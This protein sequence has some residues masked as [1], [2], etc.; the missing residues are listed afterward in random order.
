MKSDSTD[1]A[2]QLTSIAEYSKTAAALAELR[3]KYKDVIFDVATR[4][5]MA[6]AIKGRAELRGYRLAL[7]RLRVEI[8]APALKRTQEID[9][10]ARR[11]TAELLALEDPIDDQIKADE[12]RKQAEIEAKAKAEADRIAAE[13]A[14]RK[15]AEEKIL[16]AQRAEIERQQAELAERKRQQ[17]A[18]EYEARRKIEAE[19]RAAR[20]EIEEE[21][22]EAQ[23]VLD[24][25][26]E[27]MR[28]EQAE[29]NKRLREVEEKLAAERRAVE[30]QARQARAEAEA[31][32]REVRRK[33][34]E[35]NDGY[36]ILAN[37]VRR[38][39]RIDEFKA[40]AQA[41][42]PYLKKVNKEAA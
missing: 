15:A 5:G 22:R 18:I 4:E 19:E 38:F 1:V 13:E 10:E 42:G 29:E 37:F 14:A 12:R 17:D 8:K 30:E 32:E 3:G 41:I 34:N 11:I 20:A 2:V 31:R 7:E 21:R 6:T 39:G 35:V 27:K 25:Q 28:A 9:S 40:V 23:R 16:A 33:E 24:Q 26:A 36:E